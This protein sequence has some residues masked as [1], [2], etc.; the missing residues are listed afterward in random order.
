M[1]IDVRIFVRF[2]YKS[3]YGI[4]LSSSSQFTSISRDWT[5][6]HLNNRSRTVFYRESGYIDCYNF[7][8]H[9]KV[10]GEL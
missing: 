5:E 3:L 9:F 4:L 1:G 10:L 6:N 2:V 8:L 7:D